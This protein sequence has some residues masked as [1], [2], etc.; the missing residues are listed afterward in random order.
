MGHRVVLVEDWPDTRESLRHLL[1]LL[2]HQVR[3]AANGP[4]G[5]MQVLEW[6]PDV[7]IL[8]I[9]LPGLDGYQL[10]LHIRALLGDKIFLIALTAY[11]TLEDQHRS[12]KAGFDAHL[13]KPT[14]LDELFRLLTS[15]AVSPSRGDAAPANRR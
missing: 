1:E 3:V 15:S 11:A 4:E 13:A 2:G 5:L 10:A 6:Q 7:A 14:D 12:Y 9:G 8:D